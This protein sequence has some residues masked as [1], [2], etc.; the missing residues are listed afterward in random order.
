MSARDLG[1]CG[2][3]YGPR[4]HIHLQGIGPVK[5]RPAETLRAGD[6]LLWNNGGRETV[7]AVWPKGRVS[8]SV[9]TEYAGREGKVTKGMRTFRRDRLVAAGEIRGVRWVAVPEGRMTSVP[10]ACGM[11]RDA[12]ARGAKRVPAWDADFCATIVGRDDTLARLG[13]WL[14]GWDE[15]NVAAPVPA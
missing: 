8:L 11:G 5:A 13:E 10:D 4:D 9:A 7:V 2:T 3:C 1:L 12:F 14:R 15:A 6:V